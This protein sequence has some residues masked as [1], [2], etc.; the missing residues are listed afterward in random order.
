MKKIFLG[1]IGLL[2]VVLMVSGCT[3]TVGKETIIKELNV[4]GSG[5]QVQYVMVPNNSQIRVEISNI[6]TIKGIMD[7]NRI[8]FFGL[9]EEGQNGQSITNYGNTV[10]YKSFDVTN[11]FVGNNTM[12]SGMKSIAIQTADMKANIRIVAIT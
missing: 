7:M 2:L 12:K 3:S 10:D 1:L 9:A 6:T 5:S 8:E 11:G 4:G